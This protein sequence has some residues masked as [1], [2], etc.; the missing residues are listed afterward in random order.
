LNKHLT[1]LFEEVVAIYD[2]LGVGREGGREGGEGRLTFQVR[3]LF[4][5]FLVSR[6]P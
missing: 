6:L 4:V 5:Y 3:I 2:M 1:P